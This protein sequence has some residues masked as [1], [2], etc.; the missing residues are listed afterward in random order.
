MGEPIDRGQLQRLLDER[1]A[2]LVGVL[3]Y[4]GC[5]WAHLPPRSISASKT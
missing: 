3:P 2:Q 1:G 4:A 5:H